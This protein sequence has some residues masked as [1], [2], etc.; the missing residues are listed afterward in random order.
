MDLVPSLK[1]D[2]TEVIL[3]GEKFFKNEKDKTHQ[4]LISLCK[5]LNSSRNYEAKYHQ[6][7]R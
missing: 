3:R 6:L 2:D 1:V 4:S 7:F 5:A